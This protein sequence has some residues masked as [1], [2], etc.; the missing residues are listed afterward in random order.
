MPPLDL[1]AVGSDSFNG[2]EDASGSGSGSVSGVGADA[3][4]STPS[5]G[6]VSLSS[7]SVSS[8]ASSASSTPVATGPGRERHSSPWMAYPARLEPMLEEPLDSSGVNSSAGG[9]DGHAEAAVDAD[10]GVDGEAMSDSR[11]SDSSGSDVAARSIDEDANKAVAHQLLPAAASFAGLSNRLSSDD[12]H[13]S[14]VAS[15]ST[16]SDSDDADA[17][18]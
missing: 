7:S 5:S 15:Q 18:P 9:S 12:K 6:T 13:A 11:S 16:S 2:D 17:S 1:N 14:G 8:R 10:A 3:D 4:P